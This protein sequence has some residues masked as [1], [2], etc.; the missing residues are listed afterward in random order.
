[1]EQADYES[2]SKKRDHDFSR[3]RKMPFKKLMRFM[4]LGART[5]AKRTGTV[6]PENKRSGPHEPTGVQSGAAAARASMM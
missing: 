5:H 2:R 3:N 6:F 1:L 4:P